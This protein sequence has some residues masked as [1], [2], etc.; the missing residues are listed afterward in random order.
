MVNKFQNAKCKYVNSTYIAVALS[1]VELG[2]AGISSKIATH[3]RGRPTLSGSKQLAAYL[4]HVSLSI[5]FN[6][7]SS[8]LKCDP[9]TI[10]AACE[11]VEDLRD[12]H[13]LDVLIDLYEKTL[14]TW[15]KA[16]EISVK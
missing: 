4:V 2:G 5:K 6:T 9:A 3:K 11:R 14:C 8:H 10:K 15:S 1:A 13:E 12:N 16:F 7:L